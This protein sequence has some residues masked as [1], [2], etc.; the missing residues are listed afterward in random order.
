M[1][2]GFGPEDIYRVIAVRAVRLHPREQ[3]AVV[4]TTAAVDAKRYRSSRVWL[5]ETPSGLSADSPP[6]PDVVDFGWS[7][8]GERCYELTHLDGLL[9]L[10]IRPWIRGQMGEAPE[11]VYELKDAP[12]RVSWSVDARRIVFST[13][14]G[15]TADIEGHQ[16]IRGIHPF[17][18]EPKGFHNGA[19]RQV[20]LGEMTTSGTWTFREL[21]SDPVNHTLPVLSPDGDTVAYVR[22][23]AGVEG[24]YGKDCIIGL[25]LNTGT[26]RTLVQIGGPC[27]YPIWARRT[28]QFAWLGHDSRM[29]S[30][31]A[32][33]VRLYVQGAEIGAY[34]EIGIGFGR[35][36]E[37]VI[38][39]D[40]SHVAGGPRP[41][42]WGDNDRTL[43]AMATDGGVTS[44]WEFD[45]SNP[46]R[47]NAVAPGHRRVVAFEAADDGRILLAYASPEDPARV[48]LI[49]SGAES[50]VYAPNQEWLKNRRI[51]T[52]VAFD[53]TGANGDRIEGWL[54]SPSERPFQGAPCILQL[55]RGR[56]GWSFYLETQILAGAGFAV[57]YVN[58]HGSY[59]YGETFRASTHYDP[60]NL[61]VADVLA[62]L[63]HLAGIGIDTD[64]VGVNGTSFGGFL[65]NWLIT[66]H[67]ERFA[68][69]IAQASYCN[70]HSLWGTSSI[71]PS[72]WDRPGPP[73]QHAEFW[74]SRS[75]LTYVERVRIPVL[76]IHGDRDTICPLEQAEQW[77][78]ALAIRGLDP[79]WLILKGEAHDLARTA[80]PESRVLRM[81]TILRW[82]QDRLMPGQAA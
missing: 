70:R 63:D 20:I 76:L 69:A 48:A 17:K 40:T 52:P 65:V 22:P 26:Q 39:D 25:D 2:Q 32:T 78:T 31:E 77:Y 33:D 6:E 38:I 81:A 46:R 12:D 13:S 53:F 79:T 34:K 57:A 24:Y 62:A 18:R 60:A 30:T 3:C 66:Q 37:D 14:L 28:R 11:G 8:V 68:A 7:P 23:V 43:L 74:L 42:A 1:G 27:S 56:F 71:G 58:P 49:S 54:V 4:I 64:R 35:S 29:G 47:I 45:V 10:T 19:F 67:P 61:E 82:F 5:R 51:T 75:P 55:N 44:L 73:W 21:T 16:F 50:L 36:I 41:I 80:R 15:G 59:G 9:Q 72:R